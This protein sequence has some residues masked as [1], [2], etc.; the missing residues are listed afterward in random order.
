LDAVTVLIGMSKLS[1]FRHMEMKVRA[2]VDALSPFSPGR[3]NAVSQG[4]RVPALQGAASGQAGNVPK[5]LALATEL[6][7]QAPPVDYARIAQIR[8]A[9]ASGTYSI[10]PGK[11]ADAMINFG[12]SAAAS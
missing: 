10:V 3:L 4:S 6:S 9:V 8:Q 1:D 11:I 7:Q 5:L 12:R 2:M